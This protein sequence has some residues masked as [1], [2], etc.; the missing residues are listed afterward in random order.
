ME[1]KGSPVAVVKPAGGAPAA[2]WGHSDED[3]LFSSLQFG[4]SS[5]LKSISD[6]LTLRRPPPYQTAAQLVS[7]MW[8]L[9]KDASQVHTKQAES[10]TE[11]DEL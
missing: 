9:F 5:Q 11:P 8:T 2:W 3:F 10:N 1:N 6:R 4:G 7:D